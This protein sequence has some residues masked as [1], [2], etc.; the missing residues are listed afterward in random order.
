MMYGAWRIHPRRFLASFSFSASPLE[1]RA[2][3][4]DAAVVLNLASPTY[5]SAYKHE[6][7]HAHVRKYPLPKCQLRRSFPVLSTSKLFVD[8]RLSF[9][10]IGEIG[11]GCLILRSVVDCNEGCGTWKIVLQWN[12]N[13]VVPL[14][15]IIGKSEYYP[16]KSRLSFMAT[17]IWRYNVHNKESL[18]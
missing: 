5:K 12:I 18:I 8:S 3:Y 11:R 9:D 13:I 10:E 1:F 7:I 14:G 15:W 2:P 6:R 16:N 4:I 17:W